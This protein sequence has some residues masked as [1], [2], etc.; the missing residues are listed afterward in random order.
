[1]SNHHCNHGILACPQ[2]QSV[3]NEPFFSGK[4]FIWQVFDGGRD[5]TRLG[6]PM[7]AGPQRVQDLAGRQLAGSALL[8]QVAAP[9]ITGGDKVC[10]VA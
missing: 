2:R 8:K 4:G 1:M 6:N 9:H 10:I 3:F 5:P 7:I